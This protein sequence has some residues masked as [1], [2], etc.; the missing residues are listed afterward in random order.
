MND[1]SSVELAH[2]MVKVR[3]LFSHSTVHLR[4]IVKDFS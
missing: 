1:L 2:R 4:T 3:D